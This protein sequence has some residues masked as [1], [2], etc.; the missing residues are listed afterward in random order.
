[1]TDAHDRLANNRSADAGFATEAAAM[2]SLAIALLAVALIAAG[3]AGL[4]LARADL[5]RAGN[6]LTLDA[7]Q[8]QAA[9][10]L[11]AAGSSARFAWTVSA[12]GGAVR[13]EAELEG[14]KTGLADIANLDDAGLRKLGVTDGGTLRARLTALASAGAAR[15]L[16][17]ASA[18][19]SPLWRDCAR[20]MISPY[21]SAK[22]L[23]LPKA[24]AP[25]SGAFTGRPG[26]V[27]RILLTSADGW[28]DERVVR[29]TG[30]RYHPWAVVDRRFYRGGQGAFRCEAAMGM[31]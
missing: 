18:D 19:S 25:T 30:D 14:T 2:V 28:T 16:D 1:M 6:D 11:L 23:S 12:P 4:R 13:A 24:S 17:L 10:S 26:E 3:V 29:F 31:G 5:N 20:S 8:Q 15:G 22:A 7:G 27:W 21:G 9:A